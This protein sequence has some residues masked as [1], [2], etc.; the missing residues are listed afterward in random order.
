MVVEKKTT[1]GIISS[2]SLAGL[3]TVTT[4]VCRQTLMA[5]WAVYS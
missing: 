5:L 1:T 3:V 2:A 4:D